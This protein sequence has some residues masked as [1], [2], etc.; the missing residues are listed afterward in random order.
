MGAAVPNILHDP[1][2]AVS[3]QSGE[4]TFGNC[5]ITQGEFLHCRPS[6]SLN[7]LWC[8]VT[9]GWEDPMCTVPHTH[10]KH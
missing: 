6:Q 3:C 9:L 1:L 5:Q 10:F 7:V 4:S 8:G 2:V